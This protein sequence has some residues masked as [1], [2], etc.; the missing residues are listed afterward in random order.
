[1][2]LFSHG[3][4]R[5]AVPGGVRP[6][7]VGA[8]V[9]DERRAIGVEQAAIALETRSDEVQRRTADRIGF[10]DEVRQVAMMRAHRIVAAMLDPGRVPVRPGAGEIGRVALAD[11][12]DVHS[13]CARR[14]AARDEFDTKPARI[15]VDIGAAAIGALRVI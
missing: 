14:E 6:H 5:A 4:A 10:D 8:R 12:M 7:V 15:A 2:P 9:D 1:M 11:G 13:V 3:D